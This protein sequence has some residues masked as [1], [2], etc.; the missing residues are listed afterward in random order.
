[1][2]KELFV[3]QKLQ[4]TVPVTQLRY[5]TSLW[6]HFEHS[7][8]N[9]RH[10]CLVFEPMGPSASSMVEDLPCLKPQTKGMEVRYP[11]WMAKRLLRQAL[12]GLACLHANDIV[13]GD[14]QPG[15]ILFTLKDLPD[16]GKQELHQ[17]ANYKWGSISQP[18]ERLD[19]WKDEWAPDYLA[20]PQPL[21]KYADISRDFKVKLSDLGGGKYRSCLVILLS[22]NFKFRAI[23]L[24]TAS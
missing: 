22:T 8:P 3:L 14:F 5:I 12:Q 18:V 20:I 4:K 24:L 10:I 23:K 13:H 17:D 15:N 21:D 16:V 7:G 19:G 1:M 9:G 11:T 2:P 6:D